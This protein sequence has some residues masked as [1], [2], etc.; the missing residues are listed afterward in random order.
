MHAFLFGPF[1]SQTL[2]L[3]GLGLRTKIDFSSYATMAAIL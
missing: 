2:G 3:T 1:D